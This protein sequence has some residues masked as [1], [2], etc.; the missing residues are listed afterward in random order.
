MTDSV[1]KFKNRFYKLAGVLFVL[2]V[3]F[4]ASAWTNFISDQNQC[5]SSFRMIFI[6]DTALLYLKIPNILVQFML[7]KTSVLQAAHYSVDYIMNQTFTRMAEELLTEE[8]AQAL[9][10][11]QDE[12]DLEDKEP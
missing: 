3:I 11:T 10:T 4:T 2:N 6:F 9:E 7:K 8:K 1:K 12:I 5:P